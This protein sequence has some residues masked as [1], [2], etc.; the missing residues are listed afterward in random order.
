MTLLQQRATASESS[1]SPPDR[2][3]T[4]ATFFAGA[5]VLHNADH[6]RRGA[7]SVGR[8]VFWLGTAGIVLEVGLVIVI[9]QRNRRAPLA[10][11]IG[12]FS[13]ALGYV[14]VHFLPPHPW[15]SDPFIGV[16]G[17]SPLSW[18]AASVE[19]LAALCLGASGILALRTGSHETLEARRVGEAMKHPVALL[20]T[21]SQL[22]ALVIAFA[23]L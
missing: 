21:I 4:A 17:I 12:G 20:F 3:L 15:F 22:V 9:C 14:G 7:D 11:A 1:S 13:L 19:V 16:R 23:Q 18:A 8:D 10:A 5:V 6:L 2:L